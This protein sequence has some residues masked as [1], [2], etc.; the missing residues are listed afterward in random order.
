VGR[1]NVRSRVVA[2]VGGPGAAELLDVLTRSDADRAAPIGRLHQRQ[3]VEWLAE[4]L[5]DLEEDEP[6]RLRLIEALKSVPLLVDSGQELP[7][8]P[9]PP[10]PPAVEPGGSSAV[11]ALGSGILWWIA[12]LVAVLSGT[13]EPGFLLGTMLFFLPFAA[14]GF[15]LVAIKR[16]RSVPESQ[17]DLRWNLASAAAMIGLV[18][19]G[20][21]PVF[22]IGYGVTQS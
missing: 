22:L 8:P 11:A 5:I 12:V 9:P 21:G 15:G 10:P 2:A 13:E 14:V 3:D 17:H 6:A 16:L 18:V 1:L 20:V 19:G 4:L 7:R